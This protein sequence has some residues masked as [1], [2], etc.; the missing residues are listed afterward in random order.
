MT[1][2]FINAPR[3]LLLRPR[4]RQ[5]LTIHR[6]DLPFAAVF[7]NVA[8]LREVQIALAAFERW[9]VPIRPK[10]METFLSHNQKRL[11]G[12]TPLTPFASSAMGV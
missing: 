10:L 11:A 7:P 2:P 4:M 9:I 1:G 6:F 12:E 8:R 3:A 5:C